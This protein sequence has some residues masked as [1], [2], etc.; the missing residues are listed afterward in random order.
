MYSL[1]IDLSRTVIEWRIN[2][3]SESKGETICTL[4]SFT[5][6]VPRKDKCVLSSLG[7]SQPVSVRV[8]STSADIDHLLSV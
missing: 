6:Y 5:L 8:S 2:W 3:F 4:Q 1:E 7:Q